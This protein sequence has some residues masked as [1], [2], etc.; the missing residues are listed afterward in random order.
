MNQ[1][2]S[3]IWSM[4][5]RMRVFEGLH[6][7]AFRSNSSLSFIIRP[8][9]WT[10]YTFLYCRRSGYFYVLSSLA[11]RVTPEMTRTST[12]ETSIEHVFPAEF[13]RNSC[14]SQ[15]WSSMA[16][17]SWI[18]SMFKMQAIH[19]MQN[20]KTINW[21]DMND[22]NVCKIQLTMQV[23]FPRSMLSWLALL[24][25]VFHNLLQSFRKGPISFTR[26]FHNQFTFIQFEGKIN[27]FERE[28]W[29]TLRKWQ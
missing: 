29:L 14:Y 13:H 22:N 11:G 28:P 21:V 7:K 8:F 24:C 25:A 17:L 15:E 16:F 4:A 10:R 26:L 27:A 1:M 5:F 23:Q 19:A 2:V 3:W 9:K 20:R 18:N 12:I 6:E